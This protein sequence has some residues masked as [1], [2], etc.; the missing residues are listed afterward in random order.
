MEPLSTLSRLEL[1]DDLKGAYKEALIVTKNNKSLYKGY[2][3]ELEKYATKDQIISEIQYVNILSNN[4]T[5]DSQDFQ[6]V[7]L[8]IPF[9]LGLFKNIIRN[10]TNYFKTKLNMGDREMT[11]RYENK[12]D[13]LKIAIKQV[14]IL[15]EAL[16]KPYA[17][18]AKIFRKRLRFP[19]NPER[20][21]DVLEKEFKDYE[22]NK[23]LTS[24]KIN[25]VEFIPVYSS[26]NNSSIR[27]YKDTLVLL[28]PENWPISY[29]NEE[30]LDKFNGFCR[31]LTIDSVKRFLIKQDLNSINT[32]D[33][34]INTGREQVITTAEKLSE[35]V[36]SAI[37]DS[38]SYYFQFK[39]FHENMITIIDNYNDRVD[40]G[41]EINNI[42]FYFKTFK[43]TT[44]F[45]Y[46]AEDVSNFQNFFI[47]VMH[48][49]N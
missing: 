19:D 38:P 24:S 17:D 41:F 7:P 4:G 8:N 21:L 36:L 27:D 22:A 46:R 39:R 49:F 34:K 12:K 13:E 14:K 25:G 3:E 35:D 43:L 16:K 5:L 30:D 1:I 2:F 32:E 9:N 40:D 23:N 42:K 29:F 45:N 44:H 10:E 47:K 20:D 33:L 31:S 48:F 28:Q 37:Q 15:N 6:Y 18:K 26:Y 11:A